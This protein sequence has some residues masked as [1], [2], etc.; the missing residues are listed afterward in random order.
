MEPLY[1]IKKSK[2]GAQLLLLLLPVLVLFG[3]K[4]FL[5]EK[6][7]KSDIVPT[8]LDDL[9]TLLDNS[10]G[11]MNSRSAAAYSELVADNYYVTTSSWQS[12]EASDLNRVH[13]ENYIWGNIPHDVYWSYPYLGPIYYSNIVLDGLPDIKVNSDEV[14]LYNSIKGSA[15][16]YR[17]FA[18]WQ[19]AQLFSKPYSSANSDDWG[20]VLRLTSN[21][22]EKAPRATIQQTYDK[23]ISDL[24]TAADLLPTSVP[25]AT[26]P[27]KAAA[28]A[29][30]ARTYLSMGDYSN[31]GHYAD[32]ALQQ[33]N[34]LVDYNNL[35]PVGNPP[36]PS[37]NT[38]V[39]F[40]NYSP[41]PVIFSTTNH[42]IDSNLYRSYNAN[43]LRKTIF[44]K[45]GTGTNAGTYTFRGSYNG[46][47]QVN[48]VFDGLATDE[49]FLIRAECFARAGNKDAA[50]TDLNTLMQKRWKNGNWIPFSASD[51][52][53][54][55]TMILSERRKE[56]VFRGL[57]WSDIRRLN[58]EG[59]NITLTRVVAG[60]VYTLPPNDLRSVMLI[61]SGEIQ[62]N[63]RIS[64]NPR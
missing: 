59:A 48:S 19:I 53:T 24:K 32:L 6:P 37:L 22:S 50:L 39:I 46:T 42:K 44:F 36:I 11:A 30:L 60:N 26:R 43:D 14:D 55:L 51:A 41:T 58:V 18:F 3:C 25:F 2:S 16:F 8:K 31:A 29:A 23:I 56:L 35:V 1:I 45:L 4:K 49:L 33:K 20:I 15:L 38:E 17:A 28:Y 52:T 54:A 47:L 61:P 27:C 63:S 62:Y 7:N 9:Q 57:R 12:M 40:H 13:A 64:Q 10:R 34:T 5:D 21:V